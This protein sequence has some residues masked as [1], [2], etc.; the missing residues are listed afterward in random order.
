MFLIKRLQNKTGE[1][2]V[3]TKP[4]FTKFRHA[5]LILLIALLF[6]P[7]LLRTTKNHANG[8]NDHVQLH[9]ASG[10]ANNEQLRQRKIQ[11][12]VDA[13]LQ[14]AAATKQQ[15]DK[16]FWEEYIND[17][18]EI[19]ALKA[20][21]EDSISDVIDN[22][23][24][25]KNIYI[26]VGLNVQDKFFGG[27]KLQSKINTYLQPLTLH[28]DHMAIKIEKALQ[29]LSDN[30]QVSLNTYCTTVASSLLDV[31]TDYHLQPD[32]LQQF[33]IKNIQDYNI[34][35]AFNTIGA[36]SML[37]FAKPTLFTIRKIFTRAINVV[38]RSSIAGG[39]VSV[40]DGPL[41]FGDVL[42]VA[43]EVGGLSWAAYEI[44]DAQTN[45]KPALEKQLQDQ[46]TTYVREL[47]TSA[48]ANGENLLISH[49]ETMLNK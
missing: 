33:H 28:I 4:R 45:L 11:A 42:G 47:R 10:N 12:R 26:F 41:P 23:T 14:Q 24:K 27:T 25:M 37:Y 2:M 48:M 49:Q 40:A 32:A 6:V 36:G 3:A 5:I 18:N 17:V 20:I 44:Y 15:Q 43:L 9:D 21:S 29:R 7:Y 19:L 46:V 16:L 30:L 22:F 34:K 8:A 31:E 35:M 1:Q 38:L 13:I 39:T